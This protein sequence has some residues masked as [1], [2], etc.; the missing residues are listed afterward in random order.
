MPVASPVAVTQARN[1][2]R[3]LPEKPWMRVPFSR[4]TMDTRLPCRLPPDQDA[5]HGARFE[6]EA[7]GE[8]VDESQIFAVSAVTA[9]A[10]G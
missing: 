3:A 9:V 4:R 2:R 6:P 10:H 1:Q 5:V 8:D 7:D